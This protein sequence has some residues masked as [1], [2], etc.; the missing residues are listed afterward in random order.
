MGI[1]LVRLAVSSRAVRIL[2]R[3]ATSVAAPAPIM[4][5]PI[6]PKQILHPVA[7]T[8]LRVTPAPRKARNAPQ[9]HRAALPAEGSNTEKASLQPVQAAS[10]CCTSSGG[11]PEHKVEAPAQS[12]C[13]MDSKKKTSTQRNVRAR[14]K[15]RAPTNT[16]NRLCPRREL[17]EYR[18]KDSSG[19]LF[20]NIIY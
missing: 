17:F 8:S 19:M 20:G 10:F 11:Q 13:M 16:N 3:K 14:E 18:P 4:N 5:S 1:S 9:H 2:N 15:T 6:S 12:H 7:S